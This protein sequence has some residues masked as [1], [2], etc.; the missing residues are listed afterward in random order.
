MD[1]TFFIVMGVFCLCFIGLLYIRRMPNEATFSTDE[2][3]VLITKNLTPYPETKAYQPV[4]P[5]T[6]SPP[7][8]LPE[9]NCI[10]GEPIV[11]NVLLSDEFPML[12]IIFNG[13]WV[14]PGTQLRVSVYRDTDGDITRIE[15]A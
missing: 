6:S 9:M 2:T 1:F 8:F 4:Y 7:F 5:L 13:P 14:A 10:E 11:E 3:E 15:R 12:P